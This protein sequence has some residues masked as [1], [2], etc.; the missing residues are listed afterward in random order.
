LARDVP[1]RCGCHGR[2]AAL[3]LNSL[4]AGGGGR[5]LC[6]GGTGQCKHW[7]TA[8]LQEPLAQ[9][10]AAPPHAAQGW[11]V[12]G[13]QR[14][15]CSSSAAVAR[16]ERSRS[17][18]QARSLALSS[19]RA[20]VPRLVMDGCVGAWQC[21]VLPLAAS[22]CE[23]GLA[24]R[25][26]CVGDFPSLAQPPAPG[27]GHAHPLSARRRSRAAARPCLPPPAPA[28]APPSFRRRPHVSPPPTHVTQ[29][30]S[31]RGVVLRAHVLLQPPPLQLQYPLLQRKRG[32]L[33]V[34]RRAV[35]LHLEVDQR[36]GH[37]QA[38]LLAAARAAAGRLG[39]CFRGRAGGR[40]AA[41]RKV[42]AKPARAFPPP[43]HRHASAVACLL[44]RA[45]G[46]APSSEREHAPCIT[47]S[48]H[49]PALTLVYAPPCAPSWRMGARF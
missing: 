40:A 42:G 28:H 16:W 12:R 17:S 5:L 6:R 32:R 38:L 29:P 20:S 4:R 35:G 41:G 37:R 27:R 45:P 30:T 48:P 44:D 11:C 3:R 23:A 2:S 10:R 8:P 14:P 9:P 34:A 21:P 43:K 15:T 25:R 47:R 24:R 31:Q 49:R 46:G 13:A 36:A 39:V 22:Q 26:S 33:V 7:H 19:S 1:A 18:W